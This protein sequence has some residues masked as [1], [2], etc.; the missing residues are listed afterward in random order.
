LTAEEY[1]TIKEQAVSRVNVPQMRVNLEELFPSR[2]FLPPILYRMRDKFLKDKYGADG[3][4]LTDLFTIAETIK[5]LGGRF[6]FVPSSTDFSIETI[7]C[8]TKLMG[9][10]ARIYGDFKM[11]DGTHKITQYDMT[12]VFWMVIDCLL[13]S[14]FVGYT[15]NFTENSDV[16]N[17]GVEI[18]FEDSSTASAQ[19]EQTK[20]L[21]GGI[22]GYFDPFVDNE[23]D[24]VAVDQQLL[25]S[26]QR[27][28]IGIMT[29]EGSAFPLV[30]E[31]FG[32]T[33]LLDRRHFATQILSTWHGLSDP[34]Q[35]QS[36]VYKILDTPSVAMLDIDR[37]LLDN[38]C[39]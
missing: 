11:A 5:H 36:D 26:V 4:N 19:V 1:Q 22:P 2:S 18:F 34:K 33:H 29:D 37:W 31:H 25:A 8:Q 28:A 35:F 9:E 30:A 14:K 38:G 13:R 32:W 3:H 39:I 24:L 17:S 12:F 15:A 21:V 20:V 7:H 6:V 23:V 27:N 10:Y 16:I